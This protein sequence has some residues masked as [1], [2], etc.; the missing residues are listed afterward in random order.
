MA[1]CCCDGDPPDHGPDPGD[2][3]GACACCQANTVP[4][5]VDITLQGLHDVDESPNI[6]DNGEV[7]GGNRD[8]AGRDIT[9][10]CWGCGNAK[11]A[12]MNDTYTACNRTVPAGAGNGGGPEAQGIGGAD[13][14]CYWAVKL[15]DAK[16]WCSYFVVS[17]EFLPCVF[18][19]DHGNQCFPVIAL[20]NDFFNGG[21]AWIL[22]EG[23]GVPLGVAD[24]DKFNCCNF[25]ELSFSCKE[26]G[27]EHGADLN[28]P[29]LP[30]EFCGHHRGDQHWV[31]LCQEGGEPSVSSREPCPQDPDDF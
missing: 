6:W 10:N 1:D 4:A 19:E 14:D 28:Q 26:P 7:F 11:C 9:P 23:E 31:G 2:R 17:F 30:C 21:N 13:S 25:D 3:L 12:I 16:H 27:D 29:G 15:P 20:H 8:W 18:G 24:E 5:C 22:W